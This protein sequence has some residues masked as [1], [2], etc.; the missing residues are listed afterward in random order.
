M[1]STDYVPVGATSQIFPGAD[2]RPAWPS[3]LSPP[4]CRDFHAQE[5]PRVSA[6]AGSQLHL[7][8][9]AKGQKIY[10]A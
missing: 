9:Q 2:T 1:H 6:P 3:G 5:N 4:V 10:V 7:L 8:T